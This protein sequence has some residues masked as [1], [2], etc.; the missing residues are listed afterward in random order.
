MGGG[1]ESS[2]QKDLISTLSLVLGVWNEKTVFRKS[3][4]VN[5]LQVSDLTSDPCIQVNW[6]HYTKKAVLSLLLLLLGLSNVKTTYKKSWPANLLEVSNLTFDA[7]KA[8]YLPCNWFKD[9]KI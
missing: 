7:K 4:P 1:G 6:G 2:Y 5:L 8:L 3:C 9:F